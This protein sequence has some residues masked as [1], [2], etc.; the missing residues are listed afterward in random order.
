[1]GGRK[2]AC[3]RREGGTHYSFRVALLYPF[4]SFPFSSSSHPPLPPVCYNRNFG[5][6]L[7]CVVG[8]Y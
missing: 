5:G 6:G 7:L 3:G 4:L 1:M 8:M 2:G